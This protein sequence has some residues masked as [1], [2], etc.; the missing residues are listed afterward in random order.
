M[1]SQF[2]MVSHLVTCRSTVPHH[3][4]TNQ[5]PQHRAAAPPVQH[6]QPLIHH[7][8]P[9]LPRTRSV[10]PF[11]AATSAHGWTFVSRAH[12]A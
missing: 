3:R 10:M 1:V 5:V 12:S 9:P 11:A 4:T 7:I 2:R 6:I 8:Y